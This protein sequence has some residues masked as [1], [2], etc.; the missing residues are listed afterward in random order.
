[1][2]T[3]LVA[4]A[5]ATC[6]A[7]LAFG[8]GEDKTFYFTHPASKEDMTAITTM[9]R[10]VVDLQDIQP[11]AEHQALKVHG[12]IDKLVAAD[13]LF[14]QIDNPGARDAS[15]MGPEYKF[16]NA[17]EEV[18]RV[19]RV[20]PGASVADLTSLVTAIRTV[21]DLQRLFPYQTQN[22]IV[23][24]GEPARIAAAGWLV[25]QLLPYQ[26]TAPDTDSPRY[27]APVFD[28]RPGAVR[29]LIQVLRLDPK[30][31]NAQLTS[32][33]TAIRTVADIQRLFPF[34]IG[35]AIIAC[36]SAD[37]VAV[38]EWLVHE[39]SKPADTATIHQTTMSTMPGQMD[40]VV[41]LFYVGQ[42]GVS[43]DISPLA[44]EIRKT[45]D[46]QRVFPLTN[47]SAIVLRA[48]PDQ[49]P[50]AE[51]IVAKFTADAH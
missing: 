34:E 11:D 4:L 37:K 32:T 7:V 39:L 13:W 49:I 12:P 22:A 9:I 27:P 33:V 23:G 14:Q 2:R 44:T 35:K 28:S 36:G 46:I 48:R 15:G 38:A 5:T 41:R 31:T 16:L 40:G 26:G 51:S 10:T 47:P 3:T 8:Q 29:E 17:H 25:Q 1:M 30:T 18:A 21:A 6:F 45:L 43:L 24:R 20:S 42:Q 19:I 50:A